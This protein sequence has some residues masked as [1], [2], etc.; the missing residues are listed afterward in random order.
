MA[1]VTNFISLGTERFQKIEVQLAEGHAEGV[2]LAFLETEDVA[3]QRNPANIWVNVVN[4]EKLA[5]DILALLYDEALASRH[6]DNET[7]A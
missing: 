5:N 1:G 3:Y 2:H 6:V 4:A 7:E